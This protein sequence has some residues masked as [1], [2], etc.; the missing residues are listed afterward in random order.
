MLHMNCQNIVDYLFGDQRFII[1]GEQQNEQ[2]E[3][4]YYSL[5]WCHRW[6]ITKPNVMTKVQHFLKDDHFNHKYHDLLRAPILSIGDIDTDFA[7]YLSSLHLS[8]HNMQHQ[9][10]SQIN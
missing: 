10:I 1:E 2:A 3:Q 9:R 8:T 6:V 5:L 7:K 4:N